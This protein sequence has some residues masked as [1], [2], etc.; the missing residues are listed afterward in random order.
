LAAFLIALLRVKS[1]NFAELATAFGG[2]VQIDSH[3]KRLH[4]FCR[5]YKLNY[6][7]IAPAVVGV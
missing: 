6:A 3:T 7:E 4:G 5:D 1:I 2:K